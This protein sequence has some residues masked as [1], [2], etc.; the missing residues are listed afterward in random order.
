MVPSRKIDIFKVSIQIV[1]KFSVLKMDAKS[2]VEKR[3]EKMRKTWLWARIL[4]LGAAF[5]P[6]QGA[7]GAARDRPKSGSRRP[8]ELGTLNLRALCD[9]LGCNWALF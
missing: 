1:A 9:A 5:W 2:D 4:A 7:F 3:C 8:Q 6:A